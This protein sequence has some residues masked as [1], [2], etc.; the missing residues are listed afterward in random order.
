MVNNM[1]WSHRELHQLKEHTCKH[2]ENG[3]GVTELVNVEP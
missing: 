2:C 3:S 1:L